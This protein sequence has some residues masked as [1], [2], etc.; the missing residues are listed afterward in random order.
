MSPGNLFIFVVSPNPKPHHVES[1]LNRHG[2][3]VN[4]NPDG[5]KP[6]DLLEV[7]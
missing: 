1:V 6:A 5:P 4:P 3:I 7:E 2:P